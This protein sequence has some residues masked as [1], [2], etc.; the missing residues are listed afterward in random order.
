MHSA[1]WRAHSRMRGRALAG[2]ARGQRTH[3]QRGMPRSLGSSWYC[4]LV[5]NWGRGHGEAHRSELFWGPKPGRTAGG[6]QT[7]CGSNGGSDGRVARQQLRARPLQWTAIAPRTSDT[8]TT[9]AG[10]MGVS[11]S[12]PMLCTTSAFFTPRRCGGGRGGGEGFFRVHARIRRTGA[13]RPTRRVR[14]PPT[15]AW[16][17]ASD[18]R[19]CPCACLCPPAHRQRVGHEVADAGRVDANQSVLCARRVEHRPQQ[20]EGGAHLRPRGGQAASQ[21]LP[22]QRRAAPGTEQPLQTADSWNAP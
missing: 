9:S 4:R 16:R 20:V 2:R 7:G 12:S 6:V 1:K 13:D 19:A 10:P 22:E 21:A 3:V 11:S 17:G 15:P 8:S 18:N 5:P 14:M